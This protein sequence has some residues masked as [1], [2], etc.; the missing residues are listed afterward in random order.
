VILT[1]RI[2]NATILTHC[3]EFHCGVEA[4]MLSERRRI[5]TVCAA[6]LLAVAR[7]TTV[8]A[9]PR[10]KGGPTAAAT[11][12]ALVKSA[13]ARLA[14]QR[15]KTTDLYTI[16]VAGW[17]DQDVFVKELDGALASLVKVLPIGGRIVRLVNREDEIRTTPLATGNNLAA[18]VRAV[19]QIM[20]RNDD[21]LILFMTSHGGRDGIML[22]L[23]GREPRELAAE[24]VAKILNSAK[25]KNR[26]VIVSACYSGTFVQ[27]L[28]NDNTI[29]IA[30]ADSRSVSFGCAPGRDWTFFGDA[31]FNHNLRPGADLQSAF[32]NARFT[33]SAWEAKER[34]PPS[35]PQGR[36]GAALME[37]L[38]PLYAAAK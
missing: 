10:G 36:F 19:G 4:S 20:D 9:E 30:A 33:I 21:V 37:K 35:N 26:V 14:P 31:L 23:P 6:L 3:F 34:F 8:Q 17:A 11:Q 13:V 16:G 27:P 5:F 32:N 29:V 25:I 7:A 24:N 28:A 2:V 18:T 38:A 12:Q 15:K 1:L 22:Q